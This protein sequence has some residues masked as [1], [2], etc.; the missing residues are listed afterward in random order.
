MPVQIKKDEIQ[1][2]NPEIAMFV[3]LHSNRVYESEA[4]RSQFRD[5]MRSKNGSKYTLQRG[6][7]MKKNGTCVGNSL[8]NVAKRNTP[9]GVLRSGGL[10]RSENEFMHQARPALD[11]RIAALRE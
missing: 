3:E 5:E 6:P 9:L 2:D 8:L 10:G 7:Q 11:I 4:Y 1:C